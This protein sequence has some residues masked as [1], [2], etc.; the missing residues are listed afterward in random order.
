MLS[1]NATIKGDKIVL[2]GL[3][4]MQ[5]DMPQVLQRTITRGTVGTYNEAFDLLGGPKVPAGAYPVPIVTGNLR[6]LLDWLKPGERKGEFKA[7]NLEGIVYDTAEYADAIHQGTGSSAKFG[8]RPFITD[9]FERFNKGDRLAE[10]AAE[11]I[12]AEARKK[13]FK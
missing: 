12:E 11:E 13:G 7:G 2:T 9:G 6:R 5:R 4:E 3:R 8:A 1:I 10:I